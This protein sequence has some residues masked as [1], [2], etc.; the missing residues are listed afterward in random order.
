[1]PKNLSTRFS[2]MGRS[3][4]MTARRGATSVCRTAKSPKLAISRGPGGRAHRL[5]GPAHSARRHRHAGAF[6]RARPDPQG[7]S[8]DRLARR[9]PRRRDG[10]I[11]NAQHQAADDL[12]RG[13]RRQ[14]RARQRPDHCDFAFWVGGTHDNAK[15]IPELERQP[16]AAGIKVF[17][18]SS[19]GSLLVEDDDGVAQSWRRRAAARPSTA[20][21]NIA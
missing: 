5:R 19:T 8:G 1:M 15:D 12:R 13:H 21:T 20:R 6:P 11:R 4:T 14:G 2:P 16:G 10:G 18:G 9:G 3:S 7:R 17:M